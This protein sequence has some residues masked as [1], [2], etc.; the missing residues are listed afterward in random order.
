M[1]KDLSSLIPFIKQA[2]QSNNPAL[3]QQ[4]VDVN[5]LIQQQEDEQI[6]DSDLDVQH[7]QGIA[8]DGSP[9]NKDELDQFFTE[10]MPE[11]AQEENNTAK[12]F[13]KSGSVFVA[14]RSFSSLGP[15]VAPDIERFVKFTK[16]VKVIQY[17]MVVKE[18]VHKVDKHNFELALAHVRKDFEG[19]SLKKLK[20]EFYKQAEEKFVLLMNDRIID[21]H[22]FLAKAK[23]LGITSSLNVLDLTPV[24]F[25]EKQAR[26]KPVS[27][28]TELKEVVRRSKKHNDN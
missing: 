5:R 25:Q 1:K 8:P 11:L 15:N 28:L 16:S 27:I 10:V 2:M 4:A 20:D 19:K 9:I 18:L 6:V 23:V 21:G 24:R 13:G 7:E 26:M 22:H 14:D 3:A 17:G 12:E